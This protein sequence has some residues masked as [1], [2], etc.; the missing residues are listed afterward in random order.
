MSEQNTQEKIN[1]ATEQLVQELK[2]TTPEEFEKQLL[3]QEAK[4]FENQDPLDA[5]LTLF[6]LYQPQF[7]QLVNKLSTN[8]LKRVLK[9]LVAAPLAEEKIKHPNKEEKMAVQIGQR[10]LE[11]K[12]VAIMNNYSKHMKLV[13][14]QKKESN[15]ESEKTIKKENEING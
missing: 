7:S 8:G 1:E 12:F 3:Q 9:A 10:V 13:E 14:D 2:D 6:G 15:E 11:A 4:A 5:A